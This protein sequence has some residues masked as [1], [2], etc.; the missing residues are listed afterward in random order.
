MAFES[1]AR[2]YSMGWCINIFSVAFQMVALPLFLGCVAVDL[3]YALGLG[4]RALLRTEGISEYV[5]VAILPA[6]IATEGQ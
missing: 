6:T 1:L 4:V 2:F 3:L 5:D